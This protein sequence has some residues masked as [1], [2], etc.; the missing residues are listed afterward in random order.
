MTSW[1]SFLG[2]KQIS[3]QKGKKEGILPDKNF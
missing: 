1:S 2:A 3:D